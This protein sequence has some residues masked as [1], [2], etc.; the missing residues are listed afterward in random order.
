MHLSNNHPELQGLIRP[1]F[2][3][4]QAETRE[5][6]VGRGANGVAVLGLAGARQYPHTVS[7]RDH[8]APVDL[9]DAMTVDNRLVLNRIGAQNP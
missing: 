9:L 5:E 8:T 7:P 3:R 2:V 1:L 6:Q 4:Q